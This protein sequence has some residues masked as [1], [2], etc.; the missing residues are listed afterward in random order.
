MRSLRNRMQKELEL[1]VITKP[2]T[3]TV[4][5]ASKTNVGIYNKEPLFFGYL[6]NK[7]K[8]FF[9]RHLTINQIEFD[10]TEQNYKIKVY[11]KDNAFGHEIIRVA[12]PFFEQ[13]SQSIFYSCVALDDWEQE[14]GIS[15]LVPLSNGCFAFICTE[16][17]GT[18]VEHFDAYL[19]I[20]DTTARQFVDKIKIDDQYVGK[21]N[22]IE[23]DKDDK[24]SLAICEGR[25]AE[26]LKII[27]KVV[28][29]TEGQASEAGKVMLR[30]V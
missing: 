4:E 15:N 18:P 14:K 13:K 27:E 3:K 6:P 25:K 5:P 9:P 30:S 11:L 7:K 29:Y 8:R 17:S 21:I 19:K 20:Y 2:V 24:I 16:S 1:A 12:Y 22:H 26:D 23:C 10:S 28:V